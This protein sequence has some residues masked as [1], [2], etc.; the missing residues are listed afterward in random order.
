MKDTKQL[1]AKEDLA[2]AAKLDKLGLGWLA[3]VVMDI[4]KLS[5]L[6]EIYEKFGDKKGIEFI[7][8]VFEDLGVAFNYF[9]DELSRIPKEGPFITVSNHPL[10]GIDGLVLLKLISTVRPDFK[11]MANFLLKKIEPI[12]DLFIAVNP[13]EERKDAYYSGSGLKE[14][15]RH[16]KDGNGMGIFPAGEVSAYK[17][18][19][20]KVIDREWQES[21]IKLIHKMDV[22]VV[23]IYFKAK[24]SPLFYFLSTLSSTLQTAKLPS[25]LLTQRNKQI[26]VR[27]GKPVNATEIQECEDVHC[28]ANLLRERTYRLSSPLEDP[29]RLERLK[30]VVARSPK[31]PAN[32]IDETPQQ[33]IWDEI[34]ALRENGRRLTQFRTFEV[35]CAEAKEIPSILRELGRLREIT[36]RDVGEGTNEETDLDSYDYDYQHLFLWDNQAQKIVGAYRLGMGADLYKKDGIKSFYVQS[37]FKIDEEVHP[38]FEQSLEMGRA[39]IVKEYQQKPMPLFLL[40]KGIIHVVLRNPDKVRYLTGCVSISNQFST[41]SKAMMIAYVKYHFYDK[42]LGEHIHPRKEF[43]VRLSEE[44][45][46]FIQ[47]SSGEDLNKF[48]R[49]IDEVEPGNMRFPVLFKKYIKQNARIVCF[50]VDPKFN[51][52][53]DGFMYIDINDLPEQTIQPVLEELDEAT[54]QEGKKG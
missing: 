38:I 13:F 31:E 49:Y 37:L 26:L 27:I 29:S 35:Y 47:N 4:T 3:G 7:D 48:D 23:P 33:L 45:E 16:V 28:V 32:I 39:F 54:K 51:N 20:R 9:E 5:D 50:N 40:W 2:K 34:E 44:D 12:S 53:V 22:P 6:N 10:G 1:V 52:S 30:K 19:E 25:E 42:E 8:A 24:N 43:R 11:V 15:M 18:G 36:F 21:A 41:F 46:K 17:F 14:A